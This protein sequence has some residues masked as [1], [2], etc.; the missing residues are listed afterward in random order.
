MPPAHMYLRQWC[1]L[2]VFWGMTIACARAQDAPIEVIGYLPS[3]KRI[4][5]GSPLRPASLPLDKLTIIN[6]AFFVPRAD[7]SLV[8][9]DSVGDRLLLSIDPDSGL[10]PLAHSRGVRV[11]VSIGGWED[12]DLFPAVAATP[13]SRGQ[14]THS[15][16][17]A[18]RHHDFDGVDIDWEYPGYPDHMGTAADTKN[19]TALCSALRDSLDALGR[20]AGRRYLLTAALPAGGEHLRRIDVQAVSEILDWLNIMTYDYYGYWDPI[21]NHN[22][23][24]FPHP[25]SDSTRCI[26]ATFRLFHEQ[27]HVPVSRLVIGIPFYGRAYAECIAPNTPHAGPDTL[28]F[29]PGGTGYTEIAGALPL[30]ERVWDDNAG[31]PYLVHAAR[32][33][34]VS[35]EDAESV[36]AKAAYAADRGIRGVM[37]WE[38]TDDLRRDSST[39]L[40]NALTGALKAAASTVR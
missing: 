22:S 8:G 35:Y 36:R 20:S 9:K 30:F 18:V 39:P 37:I 29:T 32:R 23:P 40:L 16:M 26:D 28:F 1:L 7:G 12:S 4:V 34:F 33:V 14:F 5:D 24:L 13:A 3:W 2:A 38:I 27:L 15:C 17:D 11:V 21:A 25:G 31:V 10:V 6:Y 19:F